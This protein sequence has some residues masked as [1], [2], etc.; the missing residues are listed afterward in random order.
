[1]ASDYHEA[2]PLKIEENFQVT[3]QITKQ[4]RNT[5]H[6]LQ[7]FSILSD[8]INMTIWPCLWAKEVP[9]GLWR[10]IP[11][12]FEKDPTRMW[13]M[14]EKHL[15]VGQERSSPS[16]ILSEHVNGDIEDETGQDIHGQLVRWSSQ[17]SIL[18]NFP[19]NYILI[20]LNKS[21]L[22]AH[23]TANFSLPLISPQP[24]FSDK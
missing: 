13:L 1:M 8:F 4:N 9:S 20:L 21:A 18:A 7:C 22:Y 2:A 6:F 15:F 19:N 5:E 3:K 16:S 14:Q 12:A 17:V 23:H 10:L 24:S 11:I